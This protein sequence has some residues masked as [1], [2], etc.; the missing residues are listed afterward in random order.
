MK[1]EIE[2]KQGG[3]TDLQRL[4]EFAKSLPKKL[5]N[6]FIK[7]IIEERNH[8]LYT[9]EDIEAFFIMNHWD[10]LEEIGWLVEE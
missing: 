9:Q 7:N 6:T 10:E 3:I 8:D 1:T 2:I 4:R 5:R